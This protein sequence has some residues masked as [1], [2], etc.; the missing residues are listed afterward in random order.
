MWYAWVSG[1]VPP[2]MFQC[3]RKAPGTPGLQAL[4]GMSQHSIDIQNECRNLAKCTCCPMGTLV[5]L[6]LPPHQAGANIA[7][8]LKAPWLGQ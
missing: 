7:D 8:W 5:L 6:S 2:F 4:E 1:E 3:E